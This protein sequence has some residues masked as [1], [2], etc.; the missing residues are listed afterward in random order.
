[1]ILLNP[2]W[3]HESKYVTNYNIVQRN[4]SDSIQSKIFLFNSNTQLHI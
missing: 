4:I 3:A 1:M 2:R